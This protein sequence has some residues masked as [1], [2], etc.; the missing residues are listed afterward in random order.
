MQFDKD[1]RISGSGVVLKSGIAGGG[2]VGYWSFDEGTGTIAYD[3]SGKGYNGTLSGTILP[4]WTGGKLGGALN[5]NG[6]G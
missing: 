5:F 2:L 4:N 1:T 6:S 3:K